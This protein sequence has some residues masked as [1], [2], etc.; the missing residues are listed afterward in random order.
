MI[1]SY[2]FPDPL[3]AMPARSTL[4]TADIEECIKILY[5]I[6]D[7]LERIEETFSEDEILFSY[8]EDGWKIKQIIHHMADS[9]MNGYI[10]MKLAVTE[11]GKVITA[12][13]QDAWSLLADGNDD[14]IYSSILIL[15][16]LHERW[17]IFLQSLN[18]EQ[19]AMAYNHPEKG[20]VNVSQSIYS[21]AW[22]ALHHLAQIELAIENKITA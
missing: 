22:H 16:G 4:T 12:Y 6:P 2:L 13:D 9:H 14:E 3:Q 8:R 21:Y 1:T 20:V 17:A 15:M 19:L 18:D 5:Q 7:E 11:P 10:R